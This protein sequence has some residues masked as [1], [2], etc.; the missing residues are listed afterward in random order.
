M[1]LYATQKLSAPVLKHIEGSN[2]FQV[3]QGLRKWPCFEVHLEVSTARVLTVKPLSVLFI[4]SVTFTVCLQGVQLCA[5][6]TQR[7]NRDKDPV[8]AP[9]VLLPDEGGRQKQANKK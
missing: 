4:S 7:H 8:F 1:H 2:L 9:G 5:N 6:N 3:V